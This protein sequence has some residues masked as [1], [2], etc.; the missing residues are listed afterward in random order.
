MDKDSSLNSELK[1][2]RSH[3]LEQCKEEGG[4]AQGFRDYIAKLHR[5]E[6]LRFQKR[7]LDMLMEATTRAW[8]RPPRK[9]GPDLFTL[10]GVI[11]QEILTTPAHGLL[12]TG[13][14]LDEEASYRKVSSI[15]ASVA[16]FE[17]DAL[18][19]MR[20]AAQSSAAA[21]EQMRAVDEA[22]RRA[23]GNM[24]KRLIDLAD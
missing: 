14:L 12:L 7:V 24:K 9:S 18:I 22:K 10:N 15:Y 3:Y 21:E 8:E 6:P 13:E 11:I 23:K 4:N 2:E 1:L 20:K 16:D 19:K 17:Q 5:K